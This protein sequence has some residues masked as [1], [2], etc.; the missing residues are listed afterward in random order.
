VGARAGTIGRQDGARGRLRRLLCHPSVPVFA[1]AF[2]RH[3]RHQVAWGGN[4][5]TCSDATS[6][7]PK[8]VPGADLPRIRRGGSLSNQSHPSDSAPPRSGT[9]LV[10]GYLYI[11]SV[12]VFCV[13][14]GN[15]TIDV[16][17][18]KVGRMLIFCTGAVTHNFQIA[19]ERL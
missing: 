16:I 8:S 10:L 11:R 5:I 12:C 3:G 4:G 17:V 13:G 1:P 19:S 6:P 18:G 9:R 7:P 14:S 2:W 15:R